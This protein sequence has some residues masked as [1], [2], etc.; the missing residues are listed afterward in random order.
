MPARSVRSSGS[1]STATRVA[2]DRLVELALIE[3]RLERAAVGVAPSTVAGGGD[4]EAVGAADRAA[5]VVGIGSAPPQRRGRLLGGL[6]DRDRA[7]RP[8]RARW[9]ELGWLRSRSVGASCGRGLRRESRPTACRAAR[10]AGGVGGIAAGTGSAG[11]FGVGGGGRGTG[12]GGRRAAT[13]TGRG[14]ARE[15]PSV[16]SD[17]RAAR[18]VGELAVRVADQ[19][20]DLGG[21]LAQLGRLVAREPIRVVALGQL[22]ERGADVGVGRLVADAEHEERVELLQRL[23]LGLERA[24]RS[25]SASA[26]SSPSPRRRARPGGLAR[27]HAGTPVCGRGEPLA[28]G[29]ERALDQ[30]DRSWSGAASSLRSTP[31]PR[32]GSIDVLR[33]RRPCSS[34]TIALGSVEIDPD[35]RADRRL[36][37]PP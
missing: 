29:G 30:P 12:T 21:D 8:R 3:Q 7:L 26:T 19:D 37:S 15:R 16:A 11:S 31:A 36:V 2:G 24:T 32:C 4:A 17:L 34:I 23:G 25:C 14:A 28:L 18:L 35:Q 10:N 22:A 33:D 20:E 9:R 1:S 27:R 13:R 6:R 5:P